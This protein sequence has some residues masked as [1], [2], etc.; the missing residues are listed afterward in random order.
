M[1]T[2]DAYSLFHPVVTIALILDATVRLSNATALLSTV[3][4]IYHFSGTKNISLV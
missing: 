3:S 4:G 1:V 2:L